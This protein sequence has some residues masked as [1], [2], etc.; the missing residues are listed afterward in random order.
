[1]LEGEARAAGSHV[2]VS[3]RK[4]MKAAPGRGRV[5]MGQLLIALVSLAPGDPGSLASYLPG[6]DLFL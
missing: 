2:S 6:L 1:M 3:H 4:R 5:G